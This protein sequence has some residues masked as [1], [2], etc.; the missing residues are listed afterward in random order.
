MR[1]TVYDIPTPYTASYIIF[2]KAGKIAFLLRQNTS[3]MSGYYSLIAGKVENDESF[4][5]AAIREAK[6]EAGVDITAANLRPVLTAHRNGED[7]LWVDVV[8]EASSWDGDI[9]NAEPEVH[10]EV[11][12]FD[13]KDLPDNIVPYVKHFLE[14][15]AAGKTY[16]EYGWTSS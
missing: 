12:W 16:V 6:E 8:F 5:D 9:Y 13:P 11:A 4:T 15:I 7:S 1:Q 2:Q 14:A 10:A 3:F